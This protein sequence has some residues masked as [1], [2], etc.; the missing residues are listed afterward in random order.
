[1]KKQQFYF[2]FQLFWPL[3]QAKTNKQ[4]NDYTYV[5]EPPPITQSLFDDKSATI[6]EENIQKYWTANIPCQII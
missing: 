2:L 3:V 4:P 1:M 6:S 5:N